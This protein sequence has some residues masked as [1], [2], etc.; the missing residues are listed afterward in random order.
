MS[1]ASSVD[2]VPLGS[3]TLWLVRR[4]RSLSQAAGAYSPRRACSPVFGRRAVGIHHRCDRLHPALRLGVILPAG[5]DHQFPDR[6]RMDP[7]LRES[8]VRDH[9]ARLR[10][11]DD[12]V[13]R[14]ARRRAGRHD[15]FDLSERICPAGD[16]RDDQANSRTPR[17]CADSRIRLFRAVLSDS[18]LSDD[19]FRNSEASIFSFRALSSES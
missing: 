3:P 9:D 16:A 5:F 18:D 8:Q 12:D 10:Y 14:I 19:F 11:V 2:P 17:R 4:K 13:Y 1:V 15:S 6:Y 7:G